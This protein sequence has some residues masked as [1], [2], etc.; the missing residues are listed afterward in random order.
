LHRNVKERKTMKDFDLMHEQGF[1]L[2]DANPE[3]RPSIDDVVDFLEVKGVPP[4]DEL[5]FTFDDVYPV[6]G[7]AFYIGVQIGYQ[8]REEKESS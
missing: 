1:N 2:I 5:T 8:I 7:S 3:K 6:I 4:D